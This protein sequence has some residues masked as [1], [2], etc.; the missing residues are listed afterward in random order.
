METSARMKE[1]IKWMWSLGDYEQIARLLRPYAERLADSAGVS[2]GMTVLDVASGNGNFAIAA[3][4]RGATVVASDLTPRMVELGRTRSAAERLD[5]EWQEADAED[6]PFATGHFD[7]VASVFGAM[8]APNAERV[9]AELFRV[10]KPGGIVAM[11]NYA[12]HGYLGAI[13]QLLYRYGPSS[14]ERF[15]S[16]FRW[17]EP[18]VV[19]ERFAG[20]AAS[21]EFAPGTIRFI[22]DSVDRA[23]QSW[24]ATNG[25]LIAIKSMSSAEMLDALRRDARQLIESTGR[26][27]D[28]RLCL[29]SS[30]LQI[31]ARKTG[32]EA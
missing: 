32:I 3:A 30:Y 31:V 26:T 27:V 12:Q 17:G 29:D 23:L 18:E 7:L 20:Y 21:I 4:R 2:P 8:F 10:A 16:P 11:A 14:P 13:S 22:F 19:R 24:E 5:I 25:P 28:G 9:T 15:E 1:A 6:L